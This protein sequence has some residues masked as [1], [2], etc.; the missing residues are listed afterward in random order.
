MRLR[1]ARLVVRDN[2]GVSRG[3]VIRRGSMFSVSFR[4]AQKTNCEPGR[5]DAFS[6]DGAWSARSNQENCHS[7]VRRGS[8][9]LGMFTIQLGTRKSSSIRGGCKRQGSCGISSAL[10]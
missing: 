3:G 9:G 2:V 5:G 6:V 8:C 10:S 1:I 4:G 7:S